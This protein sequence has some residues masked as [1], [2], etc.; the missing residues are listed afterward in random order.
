MKNALSNMFCKVGIH[1][2]DDV[3]WHSICR[4]CGHE[5]FVNFYNR[6]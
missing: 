3:G 1:F 2:F 5:V 4:R 6:T